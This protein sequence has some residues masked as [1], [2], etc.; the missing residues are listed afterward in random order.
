MA[1]DSLQQTSKRL[2]DP[3]KTALSGQR[4]SQG[5]PGEA[6]NR[7]KPTRNQ[8]V[9]MP[10]RLF[11]S[12]G[13][14]KPRDSSGM[15]PEI[16]KRGPREAQDGPKSAQDRP[17]TAP[18]ELQKAILRVPNWRRLLCWSMAS[19]MAQDWR[20]GRQTVLGPPQTALASHAESK[21]EARMAK[22]QCKNKPAMQQTLQC[23]TIRI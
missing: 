4:A 16:P 3:S 15:D 2:Q 13:L 14:L 7:P 18:R 12:D 23:K 21:A 17:K 6:N 10:S 9:C 11:A 8:C 19:K 1:K 22:L 5:R 20:R